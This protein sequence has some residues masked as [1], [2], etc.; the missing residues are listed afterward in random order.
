MAEA[1][2]VRGPSISVHSKVRAR[3]EMGLACE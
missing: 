3:F 1:D 2:G